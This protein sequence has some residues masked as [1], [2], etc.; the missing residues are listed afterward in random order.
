MSVTYRGLPV[1]DSDYLE[2]GDY[3]LIKVCPE[4]GEDHWVLRDEPGRT[5]VSHEPRVEGWLGTTDN[6]ARFGRGCVRATHPRHKTPRLRLRAIRE[7]EMTVCDTRYAA[8]A[9]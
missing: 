9:D 4:R 1:S 7:D 6:V 3:Y 8:D 2:D 5:N